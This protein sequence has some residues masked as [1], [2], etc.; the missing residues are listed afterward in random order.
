[1]PLLHFYSTASQLQSI[2]HGLRANE[3]SAMIFDVDSLLS[4][5]LMLPSIPVLGNRVFACTK[6][7]RRQISD[8]ILYRA[9]GTVAWLPNIS[10][11]LF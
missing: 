11:D 9:L 5:A 7:L 8:R 3:G 1:M 10:H 4:M 6:S 2:R